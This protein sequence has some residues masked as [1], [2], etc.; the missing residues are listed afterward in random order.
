MRIM[1]EKNKVVKAGIGY[2]I[3]NYLLK[4]LSFLTVPIFSRLMKPSDYGIYNTF[5]AYEAILYIVM[6]FA[7]HSSYK[8]ALYK[9]RTIDDGAE[10]GKD[11][12]TYV[13]AT[14]MLQMISAV[15][16]F[17]LV[18]AIGQYFTQLLGLDFTSMIFLCIYS[19]AGSI[20]ACYNAHVGL[21]YQYKSFL[22]VSGIN[23]VSNIILSI[24]L[25]Y[26][27]FP[28]NRYMARIIGTTLPVT[29][30]TLFIIIK[31]FK[32][33][34]PR[35][36]KYFLPW[37]LKYSIPIISHGISQVILSQFDRIMI[38]KI[39]SS[40][41]AGI[42]SFAY[43]IYAII[44]VTARSLDNVWNPW[45]YEQMRNKNIENIKKKSNIYT[46]MMLLASIVVI[47]ISPELVKILGDEEYWSASYSVIPIVAGGFFA[48]LYT[49]PA[50]V[51]YYYEKTKFIAVGTI[52]AAIINV[53]LNLIFINKFGYIAAAYTTL[54]TYILYFVFHYIIAIK[55]HGSCVFS[56][57]TLVLY[58][59][60]LLALTALSLI[61][62]D[63][64][65]V[66]WSMAIFTGIIFIISEE[67]KVG[68]I[69]KLIKK[70]RRNV[71]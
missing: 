37:G 2:I 1:A 40:S 11:Y 14:I 31:F 21:K 10:Q 53:V 17:L 19:F 46:L 50:S 15:V 59:A 6:G 12:D 66:R 30:I 42:Y 44:N 32:K 54:F 61:F 71:K 63:F 35:N 64:I 67:R 56:T 69:S 45:F 16:W 65:F 43:N 62:I 28:Q 51:E 29:I 5:I 60:L 55:V 23:A 58:S 22:L 68:F 9:Y 57:K 24:V 3:G 47:L 36:Y 20:L 34:R 4:G 13:S 33:A 27:I 48:F 26:T 18:L 41:A 7:I 49:I 39:I 38:N 8:N 25:M 52:A 70:H